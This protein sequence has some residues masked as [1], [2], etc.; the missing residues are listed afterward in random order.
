VNFADPNGLKRIIIVKGDQGY[1]PHGNDISGWTNGIIEDI[2]RENPKA[3]IVVANDSDEAYQIAGTNPRPN[4]ELV[5]I[6]HSDRSG[7]HTDSGSLDPVEMSKRRNGMRFGKIVLIGCNTLNN[8]EE[9]AAWGRL[10]NG[11]LWGTYYFLAINWYDWGI[12]IPG[13]SNVVRYNPGRAGSESGLKHLWPPKKKEGQG[14]PTK[15]R[16]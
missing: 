12:K 10:S 3:E 7:L 1:G 5:F 6:G 16:R 4:D 14:P 2:R 11:N 15:K 13:F 8:A 9:A